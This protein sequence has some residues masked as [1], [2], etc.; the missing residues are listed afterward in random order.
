MDD[1]T[2]IPTRQ[3]LVVAALAVAVTVLAMLRPTPD[4][5]AHTD[6]V[7]PLPTGASALATD[8]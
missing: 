2:P 1:T 3:R 6:G 5:G 4:L 8:R 7:N